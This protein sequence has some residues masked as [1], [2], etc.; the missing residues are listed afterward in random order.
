MRPHVLTLGDLS[1]SPLAQNV[2]NKVPGGV[3]Q[4]ALY[5]GQGSR[6]VHSL[7]SG[8]VICRQNIVHIEDVIVIFV[9]RPVVVTRLTR[10]GEDTS[11]VVGRLVTEAGIAYCVG[12]RE[13]CREAL[14]RLHVCIK[15]ISVN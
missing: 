7:V 12:L 4:S 3:S 8:T 15:R 2:Q 14:H 10:L 5:E 13:L 1:K 9:V 6:S 11:G